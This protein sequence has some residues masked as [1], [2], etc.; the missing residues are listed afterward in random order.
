M[1]RPTAPRPADPP[2]SGPR[3][4]PAQAVQPVA[5]RK[6]WPFASGSQ[7]HLD[8]TSAPWPRPAR[9]AAAKAAAPDAPEPDQ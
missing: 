9:L 4:A 8:E 6:G 5:E 7:N 1:P 2:R 3:G